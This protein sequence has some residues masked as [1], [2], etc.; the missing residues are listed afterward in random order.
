MSEKLT[1]EQFVLLAIE[2]LVKGNMKTIHTVYSGFNPAFR[3]YF[4]GL[5]PVKEVNKL[6]TEGKISFRL[7]RGASRNVRLMPTT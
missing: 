5:D 7:C 2:R 6:V 3:E 4:P 1:V